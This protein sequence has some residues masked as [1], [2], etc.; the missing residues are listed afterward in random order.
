MRIH[1][2]PIAAG[3]VFVSL[4][5]VGAKTRAQH[6]DTAAHV[7]GATCDGSI[8]TSE[9]HKQTG[10]RVAHGGFLAAIASVPIGLLRNDARNPNQARMQVGRYVGWAGFV[11]Q[12]TGGLVYTKSMA[13]ADAWDDA[14]HH[15]AIG[16][17][18]A[19]DVETC[20]GRPMARTIELTSPDSIPESS[21]QYRART[22]NSL[23]GGSR[24]RVVT[25]NF[26]DSVVSGIK[27]TE[28]R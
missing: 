12:I 1:R 28:S 13:S 9:S 15:L 8:K 16:Q 24:L 25:V 22:R 6:I 21:W 23:F 20:L 7:T 17:A 11:A 5:L 4:S 10:R 3:T 14:L 27:V 26:R 2:L 18:T 19:A